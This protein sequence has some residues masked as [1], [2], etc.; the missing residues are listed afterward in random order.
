[1]PSTPPE[2]LRMLA[3]GVRDRIGRG[4]VVLGSTSDGKGSLVAAVSRD[5]VEA[6]VRAGELLLE[7][8][9]ALGGGGSRDP[10]LAQAGGQQGERLDEALALAREAASKALHDR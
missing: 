9:R 5:L 8:A 7:A 4:V 1:V 3:L 10:E 6:G 2:Q